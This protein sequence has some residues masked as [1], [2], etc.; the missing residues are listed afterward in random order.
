MSHSQSPQSLWTVLRGE[1][2][3]LSIGPGQREL[4]VTEGR[5]WLTLEGEHDAPAQDVWLEPG[6]SIV[7]ASGSR[8]VI[9]AWPE[10]QF[11]LLVPPSA[12]PDLARRRARADAVNPSPAWPKSLAA[13]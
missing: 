4:G 9:E 5:L 13:A 10:A 6:Q 11:Q 2:L 1:A 8:I 12:C 3:S 7:L